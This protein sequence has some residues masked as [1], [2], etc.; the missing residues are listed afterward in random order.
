MKN[1]DNIM[2]IPKNYTLFICKFAVFRNNSQRWKSFYG[3]GR[4]VERSL[5][6]KAVAAYIFIANDVESQ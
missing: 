4:V 5:S 1:K 3:I 6:G 2:L